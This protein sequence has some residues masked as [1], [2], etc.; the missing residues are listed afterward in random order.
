MWRVGLTEQS[1]RRCPGRSMNNS[2]KWAGRVVQMAQKLRIW[3]TSV[4]AE[5]AGGRRLR[6]RFTVAPDHLSR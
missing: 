5:I 4:C 2:E 6:I 3:P 1:D